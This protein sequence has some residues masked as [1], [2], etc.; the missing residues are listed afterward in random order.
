MAILAATAAVVAC[1]D[2]S[3]APPVEAV[4]AAAPSMTPPATTPEPARDAG[5][6]DAPVTPAT[7]PIPIDATVSATLSLT[8]DNNRKLYV[9]GVLV[10][11]TPYEWNTS[12]TQQVTLFRHPSKKNVIAIEGFNASSQG[13]HDR[14]ILVDLVVGSAPDGGTDAGADGGTDAGADGGA[15]GVA[16]AHLVSDTKWKVSG[17]ALAADPSWFLLDAPETGF[18]TAVAQGANG[19]SPWGNVGAI[20]PSAQWIWSFDS[21]VADKPNQEYV[22]ARR[23]FWFDASGAITDAPAS[24]P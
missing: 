18:I 19:I 16:F 11:G 21:S 20:D 13:G 2:S 23:S 3:S 22:V 10:D 5:T 12:T 14:G 6:T 17:T 9:N 4:D 1:E 24:C 15:L 7:C 8:V